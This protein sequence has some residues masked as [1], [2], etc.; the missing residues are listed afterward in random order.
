MFHYTFGK[1]R[2]SACLLAI[3]QLLTN[4]RPS[5]TVQ[6]GPYVRNIA[7]L[8]AFLRRIEQYFEFFM[9]ELGGRA[10]TPFEVKAVA[11]QYIGNPVVT[12]NAEMT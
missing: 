10:A 3:N 9:G 7:D 8:R 12:A 4:S 6:L 11:E 2:K 5:L 1:I